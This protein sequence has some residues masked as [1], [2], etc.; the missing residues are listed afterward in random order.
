MKLHLRSLGCDKNTVDAETMLYLTGEAGYEYTDDETLADICIINTCCF[1]LDAKEES[2]EN[3]LELA[4]LK[5]TANLKVLIV[6]GCMAQRYKDEILKEIPEVDALVGTSSYDKIVEAIELALKGEKN[7]AFLDIDRLPAIGEKR[8]NSTGG[9]YAYLKIAEGCN[10]SCSYCIIPSL[11]GHYRSY[12]M[13]G[14]VSQAKNLAQKGIKELILVAQ[15]TTLYGTD[16]YGKKMLPALL[17]KLCEVD[18]IEWIRILYCYPEEITD[19]LIETIKKQDKICKYLDIPIQHSSDNI[20]KAMNRRTRREELIER[21]NKLKT[22][23]PDIAI[24]TTL[25]VG[26]P[27]ETDEDVDDLEKFVTQMKFDRLGVFTYSEEEG[28]KAA[29]MDGKIDESVKESRKERIMLKQQE[30]SK[31]NLN[32]L[33]GKALKAIIDGKLDNG[34]YVGRTYMDLPWIDGFIFV[35]SANEYLS[36]DMIKV[37]VTGSSEYDLIGEEYEA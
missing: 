12:D 4:M 11:R 37:R 25:I 24:R 33:K 13:E 7:T 36:G 19:E 22:E 5:K 20:L 30:V 9:Y 31:D 2:I 28:T 23:I 6:T 29:L 16:L 15:E 10:K 35:D 26:F 34:T 3:I 18:G 1:I 21:L 17:D 32:R 14:L 8:V 27:G